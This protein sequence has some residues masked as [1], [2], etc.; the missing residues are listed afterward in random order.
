MTGAS[1][2]VDPFGSK[3][4]YERGIKKCRFLRQAQ[5]TELIEVQGQPLPTG[6][7]AEQAQLINRASR[8]VDFLKA[9]LLNWNEP[10]VK[11]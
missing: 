1:R 11:K 9:G 5:G 2:R 8:R 7:Q 3:P 6:R 4:A 10:K